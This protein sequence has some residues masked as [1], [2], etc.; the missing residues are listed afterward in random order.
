MHD[1]FLQPSFLVDFLEGDKEGHIE[2]ENKQNI[3]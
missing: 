2:F 3:P 1:S